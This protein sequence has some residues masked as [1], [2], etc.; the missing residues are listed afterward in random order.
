[1]NNLTE[2]PAILNRIMKEIYDGKMVAT[3]TALALVGAGLACL[4]MLGS[5]IGAGIATQGAAEGTKEHSS[6]F[7]KALLFAVMPQTQAIYGLIIAILILL[8][9]GV[10]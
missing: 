4:A 2:I 10:L 3:S 7:G 9:T 5:G 6:F 1:L 8:N